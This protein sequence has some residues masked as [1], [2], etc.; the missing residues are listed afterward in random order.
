MG[1]IADVRHARLEAPHAGFGFLPCSITSCTQD[2]R[3]VKAAGAFSMSDFNSIPHPFI[4]DCNASDYCAACGG[5]IDATIHRKKHEMTRTH[6]IARLEK[7]IDAAC[8]THGR[9]RL[10]HIMNGEDYSP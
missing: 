4:F 8:P 9:L 7:C 6:V 3:R 2:S 1:L 10:A 5:A